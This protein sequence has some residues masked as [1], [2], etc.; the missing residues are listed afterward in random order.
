MFLHQIVCKFS[1]FEVLSV[2]C[3]VLNFLLIYNQCEILWIV[4]SAYMRLM[5]RTDI[6]GVDLLNQPMKRDELR[7]QIQNKL[8]TDD[9][10]VCGWTK[11]VTTVH[12]PSGIHRLILNFVN[13]FAQQK[14]PDIH[15]NP[16]AKMVALLR[17]KD[18]LVYSKAIHALNATVIVIQNNAKE[19]AKLF[20]YGLTENIGHLI[21]N[22][23]GNEAFVLLLNMI[24]FADKYEYYEEMESIGPDT[25]MFGLNETVFKTGCSVSA[26][27]QQYLMET[28]G[29]LMYFYRN[30][31][32]YEAIERMKREI[33]KLQVVMKKKRNTK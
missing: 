24:F 8:M 2:I 19:I 13:P 29:R 5:Q 22:G 33:W 32:H 21:W 23:Q 18:Y 6:N 14:V 30:H 7:T 16:L 1:D 17:H 27:F 4:L 20:S 3:K 11:Q 31:G 25:F 9:L 28:V 15:R 12:V 10:L 26:E